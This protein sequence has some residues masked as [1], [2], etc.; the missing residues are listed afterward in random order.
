MG[1]TSRAVT[2]IPL[3]KS[4]SIR[5]RKNSKKGAICGRMKE[6]VAARLPRLNLCSSGVSALRLQGETWKEKRRRAEV[7][8]LCDAPKLPKGIA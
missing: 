8:S 7:T 6:L 2:T 4:S 3:T 5:V 1:G